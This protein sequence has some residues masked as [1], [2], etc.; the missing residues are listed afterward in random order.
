MNI[1]IVK[2]KVDLG[3]DEEGKKTARVGARR[4]PRLSRFS[5]GTT[6]RPCRG[7]RKFDFDINLHTMYKDSR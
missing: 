6:Q 3:L 5:E 1:T 4:Q 2:H 7:G